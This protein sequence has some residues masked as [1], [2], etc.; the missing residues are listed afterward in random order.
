MTYPIHIPYE[1]VDHWRDLYQSE[2]HMPEWILRH[3]ASEAARWGSNQELEA[4]CEWLDFY[5]SAADA[6]DLRVARSRRERRPRVT[7]GRAAPDQSH[8]REVQGQL[9]RQLQQLLR[10]QH[11]LHLRK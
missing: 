10:L 1:L 7:A 5:S 3:V 9:R 2:G 11:Q 6:D 8:V 4:C